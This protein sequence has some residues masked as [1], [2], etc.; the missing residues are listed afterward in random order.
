MRK[1]IHTFLAE[2]TYIYIYIYIAKPRIHGL[3][4]IHKSDIPLWPILSMWHSVQ[5]SL[6]KWLIQVL[7]PVLAFYSGFC[8]DDS[9]TFSSMIRQ[10]LPLLTLNSC[11]PLLFTNVPLEEVISICI[12]FSYRSPLTSIPSFPE[13][14]FVESME[15]AT[16]SVSFSFSDTMFCQYFD[17]FSIGNYSCK[18]FCWVYKKILF[19]RF[20][21]L[22]INLRFADDTLACFWSRNEALSFIQRLNDLHLSF[23]FTMDK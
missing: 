22:Y 6:A 18:Y 17:E 11:C 1:S 3:P 13:S 8:M 21:E 4:K 5:H 15:L 14:V 12:D 2:C 16:K 23:T 10:L 19:D 20:S 7:N 9:F